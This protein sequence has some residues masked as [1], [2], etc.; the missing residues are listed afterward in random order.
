M[1]MLTLSG[2]MFELEE[3][4]PGHWRADIACGRHVCKTASAAISGPGT[5]VCLFV[6]MCTVLLLHAPNI[7]VFVSQELI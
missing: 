6:S 3:R 7:V 1:K 5:I 4:R 2:C